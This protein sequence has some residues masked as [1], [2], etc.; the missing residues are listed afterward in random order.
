MWGSLRASI[1]AAGWI[2]VAFQLRFFR[3][4]GRFPSREDDLCPEGLQYLGQQ[5][6]LNVPV[7][8]QFRFRHVNARRHRVAILRYFGVR[9]TSDRD[10]SALRRWIVEDCRSSSPTVEEQIASG[11]AW[12]LANSV[13][14][15]SD[16][17]MERLVRGARNDF[18][19][20]LL[21]SIARCLPTGTRTK[22]DDSLSEPR[23]PGGFHLMKGDAGAATL[24]NVLDA[25]DRLAFLE[26][27][28][29]PRRST[30]GS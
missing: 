14:V 15:P 7:T 22:L 3:T 6:D 29:L 23:G 4:H 19:E 18:L 25:C 13:H 30:G 17:I 21:A 16:K 24:D 9:R 20:S 2:R 5:L 10:R 12:C 27:L 1:L 26:S 8:G 28:D 11:Y